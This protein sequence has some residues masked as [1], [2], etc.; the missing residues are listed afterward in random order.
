MF[1]GCLYSAPSTY[2]GGGSDGECWRMCLCGDADRC[3]LVRVRR[4][5]TAALHLLEDWLGCSVYMSGLLDLDRFYSRYSA[6][7][8]NNDF[9][10]RLG[11]VINDIRMN[12]DDFMRRWP[13]VSAD[14]TPENMHLSIRLHAMYIVLYAVFELFAHILGDQY[15]PRVEPVLDKRACVNNAQPLDFVYMVSHTPRMTQFLD[16]FTCVAFARLRHTFLPASKRL[17]PPTCAVPDGKWCGNAESASSHASPCDC[18]SDSSEHDVDGSR[19]GVDVD[20]VS[21]DRDSDSDDDS[22]SDVCEKCTGN[23]VAGGIIYADGM[24]AGTQ[25]YDAILPFEGN[26]YVVCREMARPPVNFMSPL[27][28]FLQPPVVITG[29][30]WA[31]YCQEYAGGHSG[32]TVTCASQ[33]IYDTARLRLLAGLAKVLSH[34]DGDLALIC[35]ADG[36]EPWGRTGLALVQIGPGLH[37]RALAMTRTVQYV[38]DQDMIFARSLISAL[39]MWKTALRLRDDRDSCVCV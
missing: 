14:A 31:Q 11:D 3:P 17:C 20:S 9:C 5:P 7:L 19:S 38:L 35:T 8:D 13:Q 32:I 28:S 37:G 33:L 6:W 2:F 27:D 15:L 22:D 36:N 23:I 21:G 12:E 16:T 18:M 25:S 34:P 10:T 1:G 39:P 4:M 30:T 29:A 26:T 24:C